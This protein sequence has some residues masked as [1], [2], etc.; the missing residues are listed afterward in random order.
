MREE[1]LSYVTEAI[2][3]IGGLFILPVA[4][5]ILVLCGVWAGIWINGRV[6]RVTRRYHD[7]G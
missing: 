4:I 6:K 7:D 2:Q 1:L 5:V 3:A